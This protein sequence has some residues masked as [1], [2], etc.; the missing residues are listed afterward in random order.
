M[1]PPELQLD[2]QSPDE[3][4]HSSFIPTSNFSIAIHTI[5]NNAQQSHGIV[6]HKDYTQYRSY[7]TRRLARIR[8][9]K[10]VIKAL[11]HGPKSKRE[12]IA[13][14][15]TTSVGTIKPQRKAGKHA[16]QPRDTI[17]IYQAATHEN[18][19]LD[20]IYATERAW[21]HAMELKSFYQDLLSSPAVGTSAASSGVSLKKKNQTSPGKVRQHYLNRMKKAFDHVIQLEQIV[22]SGVCDD[23]TCLEMKCYG[24]W[25]KG[26]YFCEVNRW[27]V[28]RT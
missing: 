9:A 12:S 22:V 21:A 3:T 11:S 20:G 10:P 24:S 5:L 27:K 7:L 16:F 26:N 4:T 19:I 8:H 18:Y 17:T 14:T 6:P 1:E 13:S 25:M 28:R 15:A 23:R 2:Q